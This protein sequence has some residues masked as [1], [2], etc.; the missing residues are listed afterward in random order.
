M[1]IPSDKFLQISD[2]LDKEHLERSALTSSQLK[3]RIDLSRDGL[4]IVRKGQNSR[5]ISPLFKQQVDSAKDRARARALKKLLEANARWD[6]IRRNT[7]ANDLRCIV[8]ETSTINPELCKEMLF[9]WERGFIEDKP[10]DSVRQ[11]QCSPIL[12]QR[13]EGRR[14][15]KALTKPL[16]WKVTSETP[17]TVKTAAG[18]IYRKVKLPKLGSM[19]RM[20]RPIVGLRQGKSSKRN[21]KRNP[22]NEKKSKIIGRKMNYCHNGSGESEK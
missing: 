16:N 12:L 20:Q 4:K 2:C 17:S 22:K 21:N 9:S 10:E 7:S 6:Q 13:Y 11:N 15:G 18:A 8:D 3:R 1:K 5:D 14:S 19:C